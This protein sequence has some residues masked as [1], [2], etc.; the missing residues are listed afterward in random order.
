ML[1]VLLTVEECADRGRVSVKT[2][3]REIAAFRTGMTK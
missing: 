2:I 1:S 3:R